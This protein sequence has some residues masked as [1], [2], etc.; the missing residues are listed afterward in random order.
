MH[1]LRD[2]I[3]ELRVRIYELRVQIREL[4]V[5]IYMSYELSKSYE[6]KFTS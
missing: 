2:Q 5:Q 6:F 4:R 1:E 3:Y